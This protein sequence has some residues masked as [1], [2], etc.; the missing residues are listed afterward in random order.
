MVSLYENLFTG[1]LYKTG[2][3]YELNVKTNSTARS[4]LKF[5]G[6]SVKIFFDAISYAG[7]PWFPGGH[8]I[9][10]REKIDKPDRCGSLHIFF[11]T[12]GS[13][14]DIICPL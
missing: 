1:M 7:A 10:Y 3:V 2:L 13:N 12:G 4:H 11:L 14:N 6:G 8:L 9:N 5:L